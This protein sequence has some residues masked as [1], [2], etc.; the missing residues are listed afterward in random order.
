MASPCSRTTMGPLSPVSSYSMVPADSSMVCILLS[1]LCA[2]QTDVPSL[3][4][5]PC[6]VAPHGSLVHWLLWP[7]FWQQRK[8]ARFFSLWWL[9][10]LPN[11]RTPLKPLFSFSA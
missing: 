3:L 5:P 4:A 7:V 9:Y 11:V 8:A 10:Q 2:F 1:F 6:D